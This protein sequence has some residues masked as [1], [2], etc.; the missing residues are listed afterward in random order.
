MCSRLLSQVLPRGGAM[1]RVEVLSSREAASLY[2][3]ASFMDTA[4]KIIG[5]VAAQLVC[6]RVRGAV[7]RPLY[8]RVMNQWGCE[9]S[10]MARDRA[11]LEEVPKKA[12]RPASG[13]RT[14]ISVPWFGRL[15][16]AKTSAIDQPR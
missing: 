1:G 2:G 7:L 14:L 10:F 11:P 12:H 13:L 16:L 6:R 8:W 9:L 3:A 4:A 5:H 15:W